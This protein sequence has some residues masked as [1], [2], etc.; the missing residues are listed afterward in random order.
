LKCL[1]TFKASDLHGFNKNQKYSIKTF[2]QI[3][4]SAG[5]YVS[6]YIWGTSVVQAASG[7]F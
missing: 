3:S 1:E 5:L 4:Q 6:C 2:R 7:P